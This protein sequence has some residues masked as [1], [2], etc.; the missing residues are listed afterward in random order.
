MSNNICCAVTKTTGKRCGFSALPNQ[1]L[2]GRHTR[3]KSIQRYDD[4]PKPNKA[5]LSTASRIELHTIPRLR[6]STTKIKDIQC[7]LQY[8]GITTIGL[9]KDLWQL[10][11]NLYSSMRPYITHIPTISRMQKRIRGR[12]L[13]QI[14]SLRGQGRDDLDKCVNPVDVLTL[15]SIHSIPKDRLVTYSDADKFI[16]AFDIGTLSVLLERGDDNPYTRTAFPKEVVS[17]ASELI[18]LL[19]VVRV[20]IAIDDDEEITQTPEIVIKRRT[21]KL[22]QEMDTLDQ[23]TDPAWFLDLTTSQL[24][25]LYKETEDIW[26]YRL[27]LTNEVKTKIVPPDG[28]VF[29]IPIKQVYAI[30]DRK[31]LQTTCLDVMETLIRSAPFRADRVNGCIY[32]LLG[33]VIVNRNAAEALPAY[34]TMVTGDPVGANYL[35]VAV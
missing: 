2:C 16:Y 13:A 7:T 35:D 26:N 24:T 28:K 32:V 19:K 34:Y 4:P 10:L 12:I 9:K 20:N 14:E 6:L 15:D 8:Y 23:Y 21:V 5:T 27:N 31:R 1:D 30:K 25:K 22:F 33:L 17:R 11:H 29:H 3:A 18:R